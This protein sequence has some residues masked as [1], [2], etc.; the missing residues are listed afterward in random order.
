MELIF[1]RDKW[2]LIFFCDF[3]YFRYLLLLHAFIPIE[4]WAKFGFDKIQISA[5][6]EFD[7]FQISVRIKL[8][9]VENDKYA[10]LVN[11]ENFIL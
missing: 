4:I 11:K 7:K 9:S 10:N 5:K 3:T 6:Y 8:K 2:T 1:S